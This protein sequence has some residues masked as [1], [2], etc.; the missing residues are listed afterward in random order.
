LI[1]GRRKTTI[2]KLSPSLKNFG[3]RP[4]VAHCHV[5]LGRLYR[6]TGSLPQAKT[7]LTIATTMMREMG[8]GLWLE[9]AEAEVK[10]LR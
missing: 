6:R 10:D 7:H 2:A 9:K 8:M 3:M 1:S 5:G 4:L